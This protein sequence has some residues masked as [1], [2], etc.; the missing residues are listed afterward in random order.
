MWAYKIE[1]N[2]YLLLIMLLGY[3]TLLGGFCMDG[4]VLN[5]LYAYIEAILL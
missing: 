3:S 5:T 1:Y 4:W 2:Y